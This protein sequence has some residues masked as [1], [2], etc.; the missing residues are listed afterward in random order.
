MKKFIIGL[1]VLSTMFLVGCSEEDPVLDSAKL[2]QEGVYNLMGVSSLRYEV[3]LNFDMTDTL[4]KE[5]VVAEMDVN[6]SFSSMDDGSRGSEIN[7]V[8]K[9]NSVD[10]DY[11]FDVALKQVEAFLYLKLL[12]VPTVPDMP[13]ELFASL[14]DT[15]WQIEGAST[16]DLG[17]G[18]EGFGDFGIPYEDLT[19]EGKAARDLILESNF[20]TGFEF[21]GAEELK[22][23]EAYLYTV[24]LDTDG[25]YD[26]A[27]K[28]KEL[29]GEEFTPEEKEK[30]TASLAAMKDDV[31]DVW[32]DVNTSTIAGFAGTFIV[33]EEGS[34][35]EG[36]M[37]LALYDINQ[38]FQVK[39]PVDYEVFDLGMF[40]GA[41]MATELGDEL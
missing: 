10:G 11:R 3:D 9:I 31:F 22:G 33:S 13:V 4:T 7:M 14:V 41:F 38:P 26:Y 17:L 21:K 37:D 25:I 32:I 29:K 24:G 20:F 40:F 27:L 28:S 23:N 6:G 18:V 1:V 35:V 16:E 5:E 15:W 36:G 34:L 19:E 30:M 2:L 8:A 12:D 39:A